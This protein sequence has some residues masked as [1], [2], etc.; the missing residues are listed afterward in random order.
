MKTVSTAV[1][2]AAAAVS[3]TGCATESS[4]SLE[5]A[6]VASY[7]TQYH[8]VRT[9][10]SVGT[11]DNR[12]SFQKGI[13]SDGEDR[14][15][16]QA[17]TIL[18]THLQ[19]TNR[20]NVLNRTNLNALKQESGISGK[21]H[22]LKGADYVV[23]GDVTEFGRRDVGDHQLF[24]IYWSRQIA[25]RLCKSGSEYR[26]RQYFRNRLFRTGRGRIRTFQP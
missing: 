11:F 22:N 25:N 18:V 12:S 9:P 16:S 24:G 1:V 13:F 6:K 19:Q 5:V 20:F 7:N 21:A 26:Q 3:L 4:R 17:K 23:T 8:G 2:L 15:G 14:L 10:I